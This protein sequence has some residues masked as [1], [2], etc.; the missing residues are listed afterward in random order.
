MTLS[1]TSSFNN[2]ATAARILLRWM[3]SGAF[4]DRMVDRVT[5][6]H[7]FVMELVFA[8]VRWREALDWMIR[9][10]VPRAPKL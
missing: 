4:P 7:G 5:R 1:Q 6:D 8:A 3:R 9:Q 10:L 2:R